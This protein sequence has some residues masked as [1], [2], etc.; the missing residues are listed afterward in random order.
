MNPTHIAQQAKCKLCGAVLGHFALSWPAETPF[1]AAEFKRMAEAISS[2]FQKRIQAHVQAHQP[3]VIADPSH[4]KPI[5]PEAHLSAM[6]HAQALSGN[7]LQ[8]FLWRHCDLPEAAQQFSEMTRG[9]I[10]HMTSKFTLTPEYAKTLADFVFGQILD[11]MD[12]LG[13]DLTRVDGARGDEPILD[14]LKNAFTALAARYEE[15][16]PTKGD[17]KA[18]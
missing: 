7:V 14:V 12:H 10:H 2:H 15:G 9:S 4:T 8:A 6:G 3:S 18:N 17:P 13:Y 1:A 11:V 5:P 16:H